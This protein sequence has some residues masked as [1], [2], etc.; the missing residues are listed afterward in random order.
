MHLDPR[1]GN[2]IE[3]I[4]HDGFEP[5]ALVPMNVPGPDTETARARA[6]GICAQGMAEAFG[7]LQPD[8]VVIL[9]DRY[10]M[11]AV[12]SVAAV[13]AIPIAHIAGGEI[14][15]G[16]VDDNIRHAITKLSTL[17]L[18]A[19]EEYRNRVIQMGEHPDRVI[20]TGAIGVAN[21]L[22]ESAMTADEL[23]QSLGFVIRPGTLLVTYHPATLDAEDPAV[24]FAALLE[25]LDRYPGH[26]I[27]FTYPNNDAR[28]K[29][30]IDMIQQYAASHPD[31]VNVVPSLGRRRYLAA[32]RQVTAVVG[33]SSSGIVEVPSLGIP[34]V[35]IGIRQQGRTAA[36]SVI[37][38]GDSAD[39]IAAAIGR[40]VN[41]RPG[42]M[43]CVNPYYQPDT[44]SLIVRA[45]A[46]TPSELLH[47]K[48][49]YDLPG[50]H[51]TISNTEAL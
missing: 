49:F 24:R 38:C 5:D 18:T 21:I 40:A 31:R 34:T 26:P 2:T 20:C 44:L 6:M 35:D 51:A 8:L 50:V 28:G 39:M 4:R 41:S 14:T 36:R 32:L 45:L 9:G 47:H 23:A 30:L 7:R 3:E 19:T 16:A 29:V 46:E 1:Y 11:L 15:E 33:N 48:R 10:E 27:L 12:A 25:A 43:S 13:C 22:D 17:H 37:H 42:A